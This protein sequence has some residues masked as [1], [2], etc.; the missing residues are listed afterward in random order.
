MYYVHSAFMAE[1]ELMGFVARTT[2]SIS[3][4]S[5]LLCTTH[6]TQVR[7]AVDHMRAKNGIV[8]GLA[9]IMVGERQ[10]SAK[11]VSMKQ[12]WNKLHAKDNIIV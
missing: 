8:P 11:Y 12:V 3:R 2:I 9:V 4:F 10:D 5:L 1:L 6:M 7:R